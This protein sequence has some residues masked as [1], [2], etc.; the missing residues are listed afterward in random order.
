M[1]SKV[2]LQPRPRSAFRNCLETALASHSN[3]NHPLFAELAKPERQDDLLKLVALQGYQL[4]KQ[5]AMYIGGLYH[6][7]PSAYYRKR[8]AIN[9]YE[10]ETGKLSRTANH[11]GLMEKFICALG[12]SE[13]ERDTAIALPET[14]NLINYR[15]QLVKNSSTFHMGAAAIMIASEGQNLE[16]KAGKLRHDL[17]PEAYGLTPDDM[18]FF[19]VHVKE[20]VYHVQEGL[21]LVS[22]ICTN[23]KMQY[24][25]LS[26]I[27]ETCRY[28][29][30]FYDGIYNKHRLNHNMT[31]NHTKNKMK[32]PKKQICR[33]DIHDMPGNKSEVFGH[34]RRSEMT[35]DF[36]S[37]LIRIQDSIN[38]FPAFH[39]AF[40]DLEHLLLQHEASSQVSSDLFY[41]FN[42]QQVETLRA[43]YCQWET[44]LEKRFAD[45]LIQQM[46]H[47]IA[48]YPLYTR[49]D[50]LI[51]HE[52]Q[53]I[54]K[55]PVSRLLFIGSGY[56]PITAL[57]FQNHLRTSICCID[58]SAKSVNKSLHL[59]SLM[60]CHNIDVLNKC[61]SNV[62]TSKFDVI[63][64]ALLAKPK[65]EILKNIA[66]TCSYSS[67]IICRTS[68]G[69]RQVFY[70]PT[71]YDAI[72]AS[73]QICDIAIAEND[74]TISSLLLRRNKN[75]VKQ[76]K[77]KFFSQE[78]SISYLWT[79]PFKQKQQIETLQLMNLV[80]QRETTIG[81]RWPVEWQKGMDLMKE[82]AR[83]VDEGR[84][85]LLLMSN[86]KQVI[87][88]HVL[89]V[90][91]HL[92]N[93]AHVGELSR[94]FA[95]PAYRSMSMVRGC[96]KSI[97]KYSKAIGIEILRLD[98][99]ADTQVERLWKMMG[100]EPFGAMKDYAR[101]DGHSYT[102]TLMQQRVDV[103]MARFVQ[104]E[105]K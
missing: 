103:L 51:S 64:I 53:L 97:I 20:D 57:C 84:A 73:L 25:A 47:T 21:D 74:D 59:L 105:M 33:N 7:C 60:G 86:S 54:G 70:E 56:F 81:Y 101:V 50:R 55:N 27:H 45:N 1:V 26:A 76:H 62:D 46:C 95:H 41:A 104:E 91:S 2:L 11:Q 30:H 69:S 38:N 63:I 102:G 44:E 92:P 85:H 13:I 82:T 98:V 99:R 72:P 89:L 18:I 15:W 12:I 52:I 6:H 31:Q 65:K 80:I 4:T 5:F 34:L 29:W 22:D 68:H 19:S 42:H 58:N 79:Q 39:A 17:F 78:K 32:S 43:M 37:I 94:M 49:F 77:I 87:V 100:F 3:I 40:H 61:G 83:A 93:C 10:E 96:I 66:E 8:L 28:F 36:Q 35:T 14:Q 71:T 24:D 9:L 75:H 88:G 16:R 67:V 48:D 23:T 90:P